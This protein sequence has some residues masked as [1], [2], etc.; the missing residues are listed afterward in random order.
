GTRLA[1]V[2]VPH[3]AIMDKW[4]PK[5]EGADF[6]FTPILKP[7]E[8]LRPYVNVISGLP[9]SGRFNRSP[10]AESHNLAERRPSETDTGPG[11]LCGNNRRPDRGS[12]DRTGHSASIDGTGDR[13]PFR[14]DR[15]MRS[16]LRLHLYEYTVVAHTHDADADGN[17]S[18][19]SIRA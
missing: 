16:R 10:L 3:G 2:Y 13:R 12:G 8:P 17:Q 1:F 14:P 7:L 18:A 5:T 11:C 15:R 19:E 6:E 4:M 9:Q